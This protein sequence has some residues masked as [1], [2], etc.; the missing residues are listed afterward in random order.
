MSNNNMAGKNSYGDK[1]YPP[2]EV[3]EAALSQY[4]SERLSTEQKLVRLQTEHQTVIKPS[5]L[6]ALQRKFKIPSV[7][8][9]PPEE[10]ATAYVLKK[11]AED[12]NQRNGTGTIGTLLAS[13]G[14]LIPRD[15]I[16]KILACHAPEGLERCFPGAGRI[17][18]AQLSAPGPG[19]QYH[20]DGHEKL[21]AQALKMGG[22][23]LEIYGIKDQWSSFLLHLVVVP[24]NRLADTIGHVYLDMIEKYNHIPLTMVTDKGS[25]IPFLFAHQTGLREAY[26]P[27]LD[28]TKIPPV[29]QLKSVHNTPIELLWHWFSDTCGLNIKEV[30]IS[31]YEMG[32]YNPN[33]P[34]HP[35]VVTTISFS[36][37]HLARS[38]VSQLFNWVWPK[39][40]QLQLDRFAT[41][42]NNHKVRTQRNKAN[43]SGLTPRHAFI[44]PDPTRYTKCYVEIDR[45][46]VDALREQ[47]P[48]SR[49]E[50]M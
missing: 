27:E 1:N 36:V 7:R 30:I 8:K 16:R 39:A 19:W 29:L 49:K 42:W 5:T 3:L 25:E 9:P 24:N 31:G 45:V 15:L 4:A 17:K 40:L 48:T 2:D 28:V 23:G 21:N 26:T 18:R 44:T 41:Y 47:I 33:N 20:A 35:Y 50:S 46:V 34:I 32:I 14:V 37:L 10:I 13:E 6:Y 11:V 38:L 43:M 12:V 22:V